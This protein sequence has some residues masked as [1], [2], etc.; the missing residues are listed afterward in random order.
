MTK[1]SD[2][3]AIKLGLRLGDQ[4]MDQYIRSFGFG[5][6]TGVEVP[7]ETR[8]MAKPASR[9]TKSSIGSIS[10]GQEIGVS[11]LQLVSMISTIAN[12]GIYTPPRIVAAQLAPGKP[13]TAQM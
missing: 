5:A 8:G 6:Q 12:D 11:S 4:R 10:M 7:G 9:W 1:S 2:V 3:G 13:G